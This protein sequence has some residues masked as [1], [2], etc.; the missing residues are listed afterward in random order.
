[1]AENILELIDIS[2]EFPGVKALSNVNINIKKG[3]IH[4]VVGENG[5]GKSTLMKIISGVYPHG[6]Y[7]G[8]IKFLGEERQFSGIRDSEDA[9]IAIIYQELALVKEMNIGENVYLGNE[10]LKK[11]KTI[12]WNLIMNKTSGYLKEIGLDI[13]PMTP[14]LN[15]GVG[16]QQLVEIAKALAKNAKLLILDEPTAALTEAET[17]NLLAIMQ[18]LKEKGVTCVFITHKLEEIFRVADTITVIRDGHSISTDPVENMTNDLMI[19]RMVGRDMT[20]RFPHVNHEAGETIFEVKN[21][22]VKDPELETRNL[23]D[24]VSFKLKRGE[25]LGVAGLMGSGRTELAMSI[26]GCFRGYTSGQMFLEG[27]EIRTKNPMDAIKLGISYLSEDRKK[28]GLNMLMDIEDNITLSALDKISKGGVIDQSQKVVYANKYIDEMNIKT[29]SSRQMVVNLSGGNQQKVVL[30]KWLMTD[31][32][33]LI[34]DEPTRGIDVGAKYEIYT[35]MNKLIQNGVSIIMISSELPEVLGMSDRIL[36]MHEG[37]MK[38]ILD[39]KEITQ[40]VV[41]T[42]ATGGEVK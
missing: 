11:N 9:G 14:V 31:P 2:K 36:V 28:Y 29:P 40:E 17:D 4:A 20:E 33:I 41:M 34:L 1:M 35:I 25:I 3:E 37:K 27:K 10:L 6:T 16:Q 18:Q 12:D 8:T 5:A 26:F 23:V 19:S 39:N 13:N 38:A 22:T 15:L 30:G 42:Y 7:S 32:K 24:D 21:W